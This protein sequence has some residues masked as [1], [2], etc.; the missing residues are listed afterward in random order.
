M[1]TL[2]LSNLM[3][4]SFTKKTHWSQVP[5]QVDKGCD[6]ASRLFLAL[7]SS[8]LWFLLFSVTQPKN[9]TPVAH[10]FLNRVV[11]VM[12]LIAFFMTTFPVQ[13]FGS[14]T[15]MV[16]PLCQDIGPWSNQLWR[17]PN[18]WRLS[19]ENPCYC[20]SAG[21]HLVF[22]MCVSGKKCQFKCKT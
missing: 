4:L 10:H 2:C 5:G 6:C 15:W 1:Q 17:V 20:W 18:I 8:V 12:E 19:D 11:A 7:E 13:M 16:W 14:S 22:S 9:Q 3:P 21:S